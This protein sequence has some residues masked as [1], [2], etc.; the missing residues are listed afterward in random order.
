MKNTRQ[1]RRMM[2]EIAKRGKPL[3]NDQMDALIRKEAGRLERIIIRAIMKGQG[4]R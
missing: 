2:A 1:N 4:T 3:E